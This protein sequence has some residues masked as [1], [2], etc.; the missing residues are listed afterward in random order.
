[1]PLFALG[2]FLGVADGRCFLNLVAASMHV[3]GKCREFGCIVVSLAA[4]ALHAGSQQPSQ[5]CYNLLQALHIGVVCAYGA[6][7]R[8]AGSSNNMLVVWLDWVT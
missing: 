4:A 2:Y 5:A 3:R 8:P 7:Q 1:M 6:I